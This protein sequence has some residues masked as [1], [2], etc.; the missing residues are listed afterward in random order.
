MA[1]IKVIRNTYG[2]TEYLWNG[3][4]YIYNRDKAIA[5]GGYGV[6]PYDYMEVYNQ[7]MTCKEFFNKTSGNPLAH[8]IVSYG[9]SVKDA[10]TAWKY[11]QRCAG[12]FAP[13]YQVYYCLHNKD[14][15][16][17]SFHTHLLI[18]SVSYTNGKMI[19]T[20]NDTMQP[21]TEFVSGITGEY[22]HYYYPNKKEILAAK[23]DLHF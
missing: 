15:G 5:L 6:N 21:F 19:S 14:A 10:V 23:G 20:G 16:C 9:A 13:F 17:S 11:S 1:R 8:I 3:C 4:R 22:T 12:Y 2:D 18:N 7:M